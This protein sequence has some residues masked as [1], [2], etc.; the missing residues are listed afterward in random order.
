MDLWKEAR[1]LLEWN[2]ELYFHFIGKIAAIIHYLNTAALIF[3]DGYTVGRK[4]YREGISKGNENS[5][6]KEVL[7]PP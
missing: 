1:Y 7:Y 4:C 2:K 6:Y 3:S 5:R